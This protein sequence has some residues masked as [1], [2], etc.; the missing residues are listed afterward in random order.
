MHSQTR[1]IDHFIRVLL[2]EIERTAPHSGDEP[3]TVAEIYQSLIPY[4]TH[5]DRL[6]VEMNGD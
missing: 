6:G 1:P 4:R 2:E 5:R 3:F